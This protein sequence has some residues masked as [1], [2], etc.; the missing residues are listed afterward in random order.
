LKRESLNLS[1]QVDSKELEEAVVHVP[2]GHPE[3]MKSF[4]LSALPRLR[5]RHLFASHA[6]L[7][8]TAAA[9]FIARSDLNV[10]LRWLVIVVFA[11]PSTFALY[12]VVR[13][14]P[15]LRFF[16]GVKPAQ[17]AAFGI[18]SSGA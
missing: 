3:T 2:S 17:T 4:F 13:R 9:Y 5:V 16:F 7:P 11:Y 12:E 1:S 15:V 8:L 10:W 18:D 14:I 6:T